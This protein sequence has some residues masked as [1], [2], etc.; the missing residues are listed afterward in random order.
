MITLKKIG[1]MSATAAVLVVGSFS[2][3][4]F[5]APVDAAKAPKFD[6]CHYQVEDELPLDE[7]GEPFIDEFGDTVIVDPAG[8]R[9]INIS[10]NALPA[11]IGDEDLHPGHGDGAAMDFVI[12]N[13]TDADAC[14]VLIDA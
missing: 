2:T 3:G 10:G 13:Q 11:H 6:V 12:G 8:W 14:T 7:F 1:M 5:A 9:V 4:A